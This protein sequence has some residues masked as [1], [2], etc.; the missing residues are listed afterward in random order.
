MSL[1]E[2][3]L[4]G[5]LGQDPEKRVTPN[6]KEVA[7]LS[8]ATSSKRKQDDGS[9]KEFTEWHKVT[10]FQQIAFMQYLKKGDLVYISGRL[11]YSQDEKDGIKRYYTQIICNDIQKLNKDLNQAQ[12]NEPEP[13]PTDN[14]DIPF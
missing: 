2:V 11:H 5:Y 10:V 6:G 13:A 9:Y 12:Y 3:K 1:N 8:V 4:I 7:T 14:G